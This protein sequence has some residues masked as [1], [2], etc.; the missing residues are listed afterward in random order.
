MIAF[1]LSVQNL[2][3]VAIVPIAVGTLCDDSVILLETHD[4]MVESSVC[5]LC[6]CTPGL[7]YCPLVVATAI[8]VLVLEAYSVS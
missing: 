5:I 8:N 4:S 2:F 6:E 1:H 7:F 3:A